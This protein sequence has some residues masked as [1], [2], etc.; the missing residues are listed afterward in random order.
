MPLGTSVSVLFEI[1]DKPNSL[2][3]S[4]PLHRLLVRPM[5]AMMRQRLASSRTSV[6]RSPNDLFAGLPSCSLPIQLKGQ[7]RAVLTECI[8][9]NPRDLSDDPTPNHK[10]SRAIDATYL[11]GPE[12]STWPDLRL[13][14]LLNGALRPVHGIGILELHGYHST[15]TGQ[16]P[17][18]RTEV[19]MAKARRVVA[20]VVFNQTYKGTFSAECERCLART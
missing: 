8:C 11:S 18:Y 3:L 12:L 7:K 13:V 6:L 15:S 1:V 16:R 10:E 9:Y 20:K 2:S 5:F 14:W 4:A 17:R 19:A